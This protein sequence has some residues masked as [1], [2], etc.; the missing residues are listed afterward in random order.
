MGGL[1]RSTG[2]ILGMIAVLGVFAPR[3]GAEGRRGGPGPRPPALDQML[4]RDAER[5][6]LDAETLTRVRS[7]AEAARVASEPLE[8]SREALHR[9][10]RS[11]LDRDDPELDAVMRQAER[12]GAVDTELRKLHLKMLLEIRGLLTPAQRSE[13]VRLHEERR[14]AHEERRRGAEPDAPAPAGP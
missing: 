9:E 5:I 13:L 8:E 1:T 7:I 12:I 6:G 2:L 3:A 10:M 14:A 11:M 4:E